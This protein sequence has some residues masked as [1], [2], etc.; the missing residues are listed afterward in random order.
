MNGTRM[1]RTL[2]GRWVKTIVSISPKRAA[3]GAAA[4]AEIPAS[5]FAPASSAPS[6]AGS[7]PHCSLNQKAMKRLRDEA[8][9]EGVEGEEGRQTKHDRLR[10]MEAEP[11]ADAVVDDIRARNLDRRRHEQEEQGQQQATNRVAAD[12][13]T[14]TRRPVRG[15]R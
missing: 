3:S 6:S 11:P 13:Q 9:G 10:A 7:T 1:S 4:S 8:A 15:R 14:D 5:T 12:D 2:D